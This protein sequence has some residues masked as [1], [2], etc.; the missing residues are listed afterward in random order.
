[1]ISSCL[2]W[3]LYSSSGSS[4]MVTKL[5]AVLLPVTGPWPPFI[6]DRKRRCLRW[7]AQRRKNR[8]ATTI[9]MMMMMMD[10]TAIPMSWP[11][12]DWAAVIQQLRES[13]RNKKY[14]LWNAACRYLSYCWN[15][16]SLASS[17]QKLRRG[18]Q[19]LQSR[20]RDPGVIRPLCRTRHGRSNKEKKKCLASS[21]QKLWRGSQNLKSSSCHPW[22]ASNGGVAKVTWIDRF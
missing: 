1:M 13:V 16:R 11:M 4:I 8:T 10:S 20:S 2:S 14:V 19:N 18:S 9:T 12:V 5:T 21:I 7:R 6:T 17:I 15:S 22:H 3:R